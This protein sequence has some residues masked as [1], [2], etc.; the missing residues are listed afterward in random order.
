MIHGVIPIIPL[1]DNS[2][3]GEMMGKDFMILKTLQIKDI[4]YEKHQNVH[5][6]AAF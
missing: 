3:E 4:N 1:R 6:V 2:N 5:T